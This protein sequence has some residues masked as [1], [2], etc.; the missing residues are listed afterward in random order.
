[1]TIKDLRLPDQSRGPRRFALISWTTTQVVQPPQVEGR[2]ESRI[3]DYLKKATLLKQIMSNKARRYRVINAA[4]NIATVAVSSLLLF[5]GFSG[6]DKITLY[7]SWFHSVSRQGAEFTFNLLVFALFV[8]GVLHLVFRFAEK[9]SSAE[10][11]IAALAAL[12]NE[13]EDTITSK[14]N[15]VIS[16]GPARVDLV[17]T[18]YEAIAENLPANSDREFLRAKRDLATKE[19]RRPTI[20]IS[21]Q[22][23]FDRKQQQRI[24]SSIAL[25]SRAIVDALVA[26]RSTDKALYLGGGMIRN[27]VWD[28]LH[29][30]GSPTPGDDVD[31]IHFDSADTEKRHDEAIR[32]RLTS[33]VPNARWSVKNQARMHSVNREPPYS[34]I[35]DAISRWP[36]T[37]TAFVARLDETG[38]IEF[39][40]PYGFDDLLRLLITNTPP[41]AARVDV[42]RRRAEEKQWQRLWPRLRLLLPSD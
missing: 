30:Y 5:I 16:E 9:Q 31:V 7:L 13:I 10:K 15:L 24:V 34:S 32:V 20:T 11:G 40:A 39:V 22:Q 21:P 19:S 8:V 42:I 1:M 41:F 27:A 35:E 37:A 28:H 2:Q 3:E 14:G 36:E 6:L 38:R 26:L 4:Q 18:R 25:G 17:R 29:G 12:A 33:L 23:L